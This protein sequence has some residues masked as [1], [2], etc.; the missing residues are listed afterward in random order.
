MSFPHAYVVFASRE[1][2]A[3]RS[4]RDLF[5]HRDF[6]HCF[7]VVDVPVKGSI[8]VTYSMNGIQV[9][10]EPR[11]AWNVVWWNLAYIE[12][13]NC[14]IRVRVRHRDADRF[15]MRGFMNC[16]SVVKACLFMKGAFWVLTPKQLHDRLRRDPFNSFFSKARAVEI[17]GCEEAK[18]G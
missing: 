3:L 18:H 17:R 6:Q 7:V 8:V 5:L 15:R 4:W 9:A 1:T 16:V 11:S 14:A 10:F 2:G 12:R 13:N